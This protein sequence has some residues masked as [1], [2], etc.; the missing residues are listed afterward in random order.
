MVRKETRDFIIILSLIIGIFSYA[1]FVIDITLFENLHNMSAVFDGMSWFIVSFILA[2]LFVSYLV[3]IAN[4]K[5]LIRFAAIPLWL[6]FTIMLLVTID[7]FL[8]YPYPI[9]P[10]Q[11]KLIAY[12]ILQSEDGKMIEAW[13]YLKKNN[14]TRLYTF[15]YSVVSEKA[16]KQ[17]KKEG[18][19]G[20]SVEVE[21][22]QQKKIDKEGNIVKQDPASMLRYD[23]PHKSNSLKNQTGPVQRGNPPEESDQVLKSDNSDITVTL[24]NGDSISIPYGTTFSISPS[25]ELILSDQ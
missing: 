11:S 1:I 12:R 2:T 13:M 25:G 21:L 15:P 14:R 5:F 19:Q 9:Y 10:P 6:I 24:P 23:I 7:K 20:K 8:G 22:K 16:L 3:I 18:R 4:T 17:A